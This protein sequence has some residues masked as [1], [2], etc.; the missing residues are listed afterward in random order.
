LVLVCIQTPEG[1][2][3]E[4][5]GLLSVLSGE[6]FDFI[7]A[8][9]QARK[10]AFKRADLKASGKKARAEI[11]NFARVWVVVDADK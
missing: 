1:V 11:V 7:S 4:F 5:R 2:S 8:H 9:F 10:G 3:P 6:G